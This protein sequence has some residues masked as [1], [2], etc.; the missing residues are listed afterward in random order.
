MTQPRLGFVGTSLCALSLLAA[1][2]QVSA[3]ATPPAA[4]PKP[5]PKVALPPPIEA[6]FRKAYPTATIK[7]VSKEKENGVEQY[8]VESLDGNQPRD[9][10]YKP[11]GTLVEYEE[12]VAEATVPSAVTT[13]LKT[14]YPKATVSRYEKLFK[15]GA[16]SYEIAIKG[17]AKVSEVALAPDGKWI[18]P[19]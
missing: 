16:V 18:S 15:N 6:A 1:V 3:Q 10:I 8:E 11:D 17:V 12:Q 5:A 19:K 13:A 7:N 9:L 2:V 4:Q 14:R